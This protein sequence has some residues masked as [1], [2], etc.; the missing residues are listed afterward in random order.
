MIVS[1]FSFHQKLCWV[2][3]VV[4]G[5][6]VMFW[7]GHVDRSNGPT[8]LHNSGLKGY[9][10]IKA[11]HMDQ[12][13]NCLSSDIG[14]TQCGIAVALALKHDCHY[15]DSHGATSSMSKINVHLQTYVHNNNNISNM[16]WPHMLLP[17]LYK[18]SG[19]I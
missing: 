19:K 2:S 3:L 6:G 1:L 18:S 14:G 17:V 4:V 13:R 12:V 5:F 10:R 11:E 8:T 9:T 7:C 15:H 16:K